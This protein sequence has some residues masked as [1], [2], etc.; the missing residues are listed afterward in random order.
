[1]HAT[2]RGRA[3]RV[4]DVEARRLHWRE[5]FEVIG[6]CGAEVPLSGTSE[7]HCSGPLEESGSRA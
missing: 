2:E 7:C 6:H 4:T 3:G 1:M 5:E